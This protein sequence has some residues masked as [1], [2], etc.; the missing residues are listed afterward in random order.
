MWFNARIQLYNKFTILLQKL[1]RDQLNT[2][3]DDIVGMGIKLNRITKGTFSIIYEMDFSETNL[4]I[5]NGAILRLFGASYREHKLVEYSKNNGIILNIL[6][7]PEDLRISAICLKFLLERKSPNFLFLYEVILCNRCFEVFA[8]PKKPEKPDKKPEKKIKLRDENCWL[9]FN[10][11]ANDILK[12]NYFPNDS[13][14]QLGM[15][16]Q[17]LFS[18]FLIQKEIGFIHGDIRCRNILVMRC[19]TLENKYFI[20]ECMGQ[21]FYIK[22]HNYIPI[23]TDFNTGKIYNPVYSSNRHS[24][25]TSVCVWDQQF[26][27]NSKALPSELKESNDFVLNPIIE[28]TS[29]IQDVLR[30]FYGGPMVLQNDVHRGMP[31]TTD[32]KILLKPWITKKY[33]GVSKWPT[34]GD[35]YALVS[36]I[37]MIRALYI[38][39]SIPIDSSMIVEKFSI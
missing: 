17:I 38:P 1:I 3:L 35:Y 14:K 25:S 24:K 15:I 10:E 28:F 23:L 30:M 6:Y 26:T 36:A 18:L 20:F 19:D 33:E 9:S 11:K 21:E 27:G 31:L 32:L 7:L 34:D 16:L 13:E 5:P 22:L 39:P 29:D 4:K 12:P 37:G 2:C 8:K